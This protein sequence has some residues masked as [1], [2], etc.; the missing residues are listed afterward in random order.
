LKQFKIHNSREVEILI[1]MLD[2]RVSESPSIA[3]MLGSMG[4]IRAVEPLIQALKDQ[5]S[6]LRYYA[7]RALGKLGDIRALPALEWMAQNDIDQTGG[8]FNRDI[9]SKAIKMIKG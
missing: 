6:S 9:A 2:K 8:K 1:E 5:K 7:A 3:T 4:D